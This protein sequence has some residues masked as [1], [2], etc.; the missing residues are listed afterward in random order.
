MVMNRDE[1][2]ALAREAGLR[3]AGNPD[4][5]NAPTVTRLGRF[6]ALVEAKAAAREREACMALVD[7][8]ADEWGH[9]DKYIA[10]AAADHLSDAIRA[11]LDKGVDHG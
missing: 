8:I 10:Q 3:V 6:V 7:R 9:S 4:S 11:R 2:T 1:V 5:L